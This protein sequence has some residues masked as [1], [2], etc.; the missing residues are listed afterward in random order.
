MPENI[1]GFTAR[2]E[3]EFYSE[4]REQEQEIDNTMNTVTMKNTYTP[5]PLRESRQDRNTA[6]IQSDIDLM[7]V[8]YAERRN[9][10]NPR[11]QAVVG[12]SLVTV[13]IGAPAI[14]AAIFHFLS[15]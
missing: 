3:H 2:K 5:R 6:R 11:H 12:W 7:R 4:L 13:A 15:I 10:N 14:A 9:I 1:D 8:M